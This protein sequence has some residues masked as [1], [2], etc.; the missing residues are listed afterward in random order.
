MDKMYCKTILKKFVFQYSNSSFIIDNTIYY[1]L[2]D[3]K[4]VWAKL[5]VQHPDLVSLETLG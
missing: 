1:N 5:M 2:A 3:G 4:N